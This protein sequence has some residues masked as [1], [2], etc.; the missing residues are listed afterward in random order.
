[1]SEDYSHINKGSVWVDSNGTTVKVDQTGKMIG[2]VQSKGTRYVSTIEDFLKLHKPFRL[3]EGKFYRTRY[4]RKMGPVK[5]RSANDTFYIDIRF[6]WFPDGSFYQ[7][8]ESV[9]DLIAEWVEIETETE[10]EFR[11]EVGKFYRR[12]DGEK[13][14]PMK[15]FKGLDGI[16]MS[17]ELFTSNGEIWHPK[18]NFY[19]N[20]ESSF[21][22]IEEWTEP[23]LKLEV[24]KCYRTRDG[25]K[26]GPVQCNTLRYYNHQDDNEE[27]PSFVTLEILVANVGDDG[28]LYY[29]PDGRHGRGLTNCDLVEEWVETE[30]NTGLKLEENKFYRMR[31]GQKVGPMKLFEKFGQAPLNDGPIVHFNLDGTHLHGYG[32]YDLVEEWVETEPEFEPEPKSNPEIE[33]VKDMISVLQDYL[34]KKDNSK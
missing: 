15:L 9:H 34:K 23:E 17:T 31:D 30:M 18:G 8:M 12:R 3:E 22:I 10:P 11:L 19:S 5:Y 4:G 32:A 7:G 14:G 24:G 2:Y 1:M 27:I 29:L 28:E 16:S 25:R 33:L 20:T 6:I 21:D 26:A 13:V